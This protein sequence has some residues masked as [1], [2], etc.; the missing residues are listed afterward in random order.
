MGSMDG[1]LIIDREEQLQDNHT[2][3]KN[4][5]EIYFKIPVVAIRDR[6]Y[7]NCENLTKVVFE[8]NVGKIGKEAFAVCMIEELIFKE[9]S[10]EKSS[11]N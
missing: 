2:F 5:R 4:I 1:I 6:A 8:K 9:T 10:Y 3:D 7:F 11:I